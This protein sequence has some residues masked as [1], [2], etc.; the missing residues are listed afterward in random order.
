[1]EEYIKDV[2]LKQDTCNWLLNKTWENK[3]VFF[4]G[5]FSIVKY[6]CNIIIQEVYAFFSLTIFT[7]F[8]ADNLSTSI[9]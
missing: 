4:E 7:Y 1:M 3:F 2:R 8:Q 9:I 5:T 6:F